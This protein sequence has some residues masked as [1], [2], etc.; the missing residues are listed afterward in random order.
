MSSYRV[1]YASLISDFYGWV[2]FPKLG[3]EGLS[4]L[5][6]CSFVLNCIMKLYPLI[7]RNLV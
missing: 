3:S 5:L 1:I 4:L 7:L 6:K 2:F